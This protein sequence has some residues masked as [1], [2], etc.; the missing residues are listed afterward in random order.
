MNQQRINHT[1]IGL[2][3]LYIA[4]TFASDLNE[5]YDGAENK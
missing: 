3:A 1:F 4:D 2:Y 5:H